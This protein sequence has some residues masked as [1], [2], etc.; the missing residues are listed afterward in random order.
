MLPVS[1]WFHQ[2]AFYSA[3]WHLPPRNLTLLQSQG[4]NFF[5]LVQPIAILLEGMFS[6]VT[7]RKISGPFGLLWSYLII[8]GFGCVAAQ[9]WLA[10]VS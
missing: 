4:A 6:K 1:A 2:Q 9:S 5:F 8:V 10:Q 3:N 7:G